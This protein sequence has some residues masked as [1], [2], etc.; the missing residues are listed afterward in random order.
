MSTEWM[1][2]ANDLTARVERARLHFLSDVE[3]EAAVA[4]ARQFMNAVSEDEFVGFVQVGMT[5]TQNA[6]HG[7]SV[8]AAARAVLYLARHG[9]PRGLPSP[10]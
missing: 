3:L 5:S 9:I 2:C 1:E 4:I 8:E 7:E 10:D 6:L